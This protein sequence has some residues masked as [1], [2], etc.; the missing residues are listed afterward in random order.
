MPN[1]APQARG[2]PGP[3]VPNG[4]MPPNGQNGTPGGSG[5]NLTVPGQSRPPRPMPQQMG[6]PMPNG[7]RV[8]QMPMNGVSPAPMQTM[9]GQ[10]P[11]PNP[12]VS[13]GLIN[14]AARTAEEQRAM[15]QMQ[16]QGKIPGQAPQVHSSPPRMNG[17]SQPG[18]PMQNM[19]AF[20]A[21]AMPQMNSI[22]PSSG[23]GQGQAGSPRMGQPTTQTVHDMQYRR[24][25][26]AFKEKYPTANPEHIANLITD[27]MK[28]NMQSKQGL[29]Q[30]AMNAAAGAGGMGG[31]NGMPRVPVGT[32][33][34][35]D[36]SPQLYAQMMK[37]QQENQQKAE[38]ARQAANAL[39]ASAS[40]GKNGGMSSGQQ[41]QGHAHRN[42]S[43]S[44]Q[45][46]Q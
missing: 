41:A 21:N 29:A 25:E 10:L 18:F 39:A 17:M 42:S 30:S 33:V 13:V 37:Q 31:M 9:Q 40:Q 36:T 43:G 8:P 7:L 34:G 44:V 19:M 24:L 2:P 3:S 15:I 12:A 14:Q 45:S 16:Q 32:A 11:M 5:Q 22:A 27:H 28:K 4:Q 6:Q 20:N 35:V 1:G 26:A 46:T 38:I 23:N